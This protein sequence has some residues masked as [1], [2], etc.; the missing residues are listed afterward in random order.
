[1]TILH[2]LVA[3]Y[4]QLAAAGK[5]PIPGFAPAKISF[6]IVLDRDGAYFDTQ[7]ERDGTGK[8]PR[9]RDV[10]APA[11]PKRTAGIASGTFW[12]KTAYVFGHTAID[13]A[14]ST[15]KQA[16]EEA[17][18]VKEHA[19]FLAR[20]ESLLASETDAGCRALLLFLRQW[21]PERYDTLRY[22]TE[23][24]D[25]NV[26]FRL[27]GEPG[28]IHDRPAARALLAQEKAGGAGS[29]YGPCLVTGRH[30]P[31]A[32]LHPSIMGVPGAQSSGAALVSFNL[33]AFKSYGRTQGFNAPI[34]E[35]AAFAYATAL[36]D[37]L[38]PSG[39]TNKGRPDYRQRVM[40]GDTATVFWAEYDEENALM[41]LADEENAFMRLALEG[42][43]SE[44][45]DEPA[46]D[47]VAENH[48]VR[49]AMRHLQDGM[50]LQD[51]A[52]TLDPATRAYVLGLS[53]NAA[54]LS[55]R[56]WIDQSLGDFAL[57]M[58]QHW[59]DLRLATP[60]PRKTAALW[61][62]LKE[63]T[64]PAKDEKNKKAIAILAGEM[65]RSI[66]LGLEYPASLLPQLLLRIRADGNP[67]Y[68]RVQMLKAVLVRNARLRAAAHASRD[69]G[70]DQ[71]V[72]LNRGET[73]TAYNLGRLFR[74]LEVAQYHSVNK[75]K[76][77]VSQENSNS[78]A[79]SSGINASIKD[80]FI[81]KASSSPR[82]VFPRLIALGQHHL[83]DMKK[84]SEKTRKAAFWLETEFAAIMQH[85]PSDF[86]MPSTL[87]LEQQARFF[88]GYYH[89]RH[90]SGKDQPELDTVIEDE[91]DV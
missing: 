6:T 31:I 64:P 69:T 81:S 45:D 51:A 74:L 43:R 11:I 79:K 67:S 13:P 52:P 53:P 57:H 25:Q 59:Q 78:D 55:V 68:R 12:D 18:L 47:A 33:D 5:V 61:Q 26:A 16:K 38:A 85:F 87:T 4:N 49:E 73:E 29:V 42:E 86:E 2:A 9:P 88:V 82:Y 37:L 41:R 23:M 3:R 75:G 27:K 7:D 54:R 1:M 72:G 14:L 90:N 21:S 76:P 80:R 65:M 19:A 50:A 24:L 39:K 36:N 63:V 17:R 77:A 15:A 62:L 46:T 58:Q 91:K 10:V 83:A 71:L 44:D 32:R 89:Q 28:Y 70:E 35:A 20:H 60:N 8:K 56:F 40:L 48:A 66:L 30:A 22:A 84:I 34:S